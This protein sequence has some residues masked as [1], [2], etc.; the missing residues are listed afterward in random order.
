MQSDFAPAEGARSSCGSDLER[1]G[2]ANEK[3]VHGRRENETHARPL[4]SLISSS[5]ASTSHQGIA[6]MHLLSRAGT[7]SSQFV[8]VITRES[9]VSFARL[10]MSCWMVL[11]RSE[12]VSEMLA[13]GIAFLTPVSRRTEKVCCLARSLGPISRRS[14]TPCNQQINAI[15]QNFGSR[16]RWIT[17]CSQ[18]LNL[19]PGV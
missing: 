6:T 11:R 13:R 5:Q 9:Y 10:N 14:G 8:T 19:Y 17:F 7:R 1:K 18:S 16:K 3:K 12:T 15:A 2:T 4:R